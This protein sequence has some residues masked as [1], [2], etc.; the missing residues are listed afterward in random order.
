M[1]AGMQGLL[2]SLQ[3]TG[4]ALTVH[5]GQG[6]HTASCAGTAGAGCTG[7]HGHSGVA[8]LTGMDLAHM[9]AE[10]TQGVHYLHSQ[11]YAVRCVIAAYRR[12]GKAT[13]TSGPHAVGKGSQV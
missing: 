4:V 11:M 5:V 1:Q 10:S 3:R 2:S 12:L 6:D 7:L 13:V 9:Y 8:H